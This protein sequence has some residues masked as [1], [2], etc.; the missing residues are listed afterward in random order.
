MGYELFKVCYR[1]RNQRI[2][3]DTF[4]ELSHEFRRDLNFSPI[5]TDSFKVWEKLQIDRA[6]I[7]YYENNDMALKY[8]EESDENGSSPNEIN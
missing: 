3:K 4:L 5:E 6:R 8:V 1:F 2:S 7:N